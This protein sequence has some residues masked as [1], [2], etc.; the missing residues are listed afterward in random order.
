M[1][2]LAVCIIGCSSPQ[3]HLPITES[4]NPDQAYYSE[5]LRMVEEKVE[6]QPDDL[7]LR[8]K[9]ASYHQTLSWPAA[10]DANIEAI[11]RMAPKDPQ[12]MVLVADYYIHKNDF[13]RSWIYAQ[14]ADRLGSDH[15]SLSLIKS[16]YYY[17]KRDFDE[18]GRYLK[19]YFDTGGKLPE[20]FMVAS[21]LKL[22]KKDTAEA[23]GILAKGIEANP[24]HAGMTRL[25]VRLLQ[26]QGRLNELS[27]LIERYSEATGD[28][29]T[30]RNEL[31]NAYFRS[32]SYKKASSLA[33]SWPSPGEN[34]LFQYGS[35]LLESSMPD[36]A[37][38]YADKML[39][40]DSLSV[41]AR[42]LKGRYYNR[43]GRLGD[44]YNFYTAAL[45]L[46]STNQIALEERGIVI[47]KIAYLRKLKEQQ[48]A[49]PVFDLTPKKSDN[50]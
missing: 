40:E 31:L 21:E 14:Q 45:E 19:N 10:A 22:Q 16:K 15:P 20:A 46:D 7:G 6:V 8:I 2:W 36:S 17:S 12:A 5:L 33:G 28:S 35:L 29:T 39:A 1:G 38:W 47:G 25:E 4:P 9:L 43:R 18:A 27:A 23:L 11:L 30:Y 50:R 37:S 48:A 32:G 3:S 41:E 26:R 49:M 44:A 42:L 24:G 34:G 13:E